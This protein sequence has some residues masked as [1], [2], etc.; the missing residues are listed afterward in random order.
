MAEAE[1][2]AFSALKWLVRILRAIVEPAT[3]FAI[4]RQSQ[5]LQRRAVGPK[6]VSGE[7]VRVTMAF[8]GFHKE[9]QRGLTVSF[10]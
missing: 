7:D 2:G 6:L 3:G 4:V 1:H 9:F 5:I 10:L 8:H